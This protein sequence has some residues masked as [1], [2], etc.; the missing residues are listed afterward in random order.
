MILR[1]YKIVSELITCMDE[2]SVS[3]RRKILFH[4]QKP[5]KGLQMK[6]IWRSLF[7]T[8]GCLQNWMWSIVRTIL[9]ALIMKI[10]LKYSRHYLCLHSYGT[11]KNVPVA[12]ISK[13]KFFYFLFFS[14]FLFKTHR[15]FVLCKNLAKIK[16]FGSYLGKMIRNW[17]NTC[18]LFF[19]CSVSSSLL[20]TKY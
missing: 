4:L 16:Q 5:N 13:A 1:W 20:N 14:F 17:K 19:S 2:H 10:F 7:F 12:C 6:I 9:Y 8:Y 15:A 11:V 18:F 3:N